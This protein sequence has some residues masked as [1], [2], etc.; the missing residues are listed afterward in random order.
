MK[1]H[2][3]T[4]TWI[5]NKRVII[6]LLIYVLI[7]AGLFLFRFSSGYPLLYGQESYAHLSSIQN[8][9]EGITS[10]WQ[11]H[12]FEMFL[13]LLLT[14]IPQSVLFLI[15]PI[16][17]IGSI[18]LF[19]QLTK[20]NEF[21][22]LNATYWGILMCITP[23]FIFTVTTLSIYS[24]ILFL[25]LLG[26]I[27][28]QSKNKTI[29][30]LFIPLFAIIGASEII[31][32]ILLLIILF[33][34][35]FS[36]KETIVEK[37]T[38]KTTIWQKIMSTILQKKNTPITLGIIS[39]MI[40]ILYSYITHTLRL[41]AFTISTQDILRDGISDFGAISGISIFI[42]ILA[43]TGLFYVY[44]QRKILYIS[45][46][47]L[48]PVYLFNTHS[49]FLLSILLCYAAAHA[50]ARLT[51][52]KWQINDLKT[53]TLFILALGIIFSSIT[54]VERASIYSPSFE[55]L[56]IFEWLENYETSSN[57]TVLTLAQNTY[58]VTYATS[59][60]A[61][62]HSLFFPNKNNIYDQS[63]IEIETKNVGSEIFSLAYQH[64]LFP[65]LDEYNV[66]YIHIDPITKTLLTKDQGIRFLLRNE[67]FKMI[68]TSENHEIWEY[69]QDS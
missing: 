15:A 11:L 66:K 13:Y 30:L 49:I 44:K 58:F 2:T 47:I 53:I 20:S 51:K 23:A 39:I 22:T 3:K 59:F 33:I 9:Q 24:F 5:T 35:L 62:D 10:F 54:F 50:L 67:N 16:L 6:T 36:K 56:E 38:N 25:A 55:T 65:I 61:F 4:N 42:F 31:S 43:I 19:I 18:L 41:V 12:V 45:V 57:T 69:N 40:G 68:H 46:I 26:F 27:L 8:V 37:T 32:S 7:I 63:I 64:L 29:K 60:S 34:F 17:G 21:D 48:I 1:F 52:R 14:F 28:L